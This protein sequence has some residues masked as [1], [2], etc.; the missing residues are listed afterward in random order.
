MV[1]VEVHV[2]QPAERGVVGHHPAEADLRL[3]RVVDPVAVRA[4]DRRPHPGQLASEHPVRI[5][6]QPTVQATD[7]KS[8]PVVSQQISVFAN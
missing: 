4:G 2:A 8:I 3:G 7:I 1:R 6:G 5:L